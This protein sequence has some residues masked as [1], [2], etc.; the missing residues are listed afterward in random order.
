MTASEII[1]ESLVRLSEATRASIRTIKGIP[2]F[3]M[4][5]K[6][7]IAISIVSVLISI[8]IFLSWVELS[9]ALAIF[10][11]CFFVLKLLDRFIK[12]QHPLIKVTVGLATGTAA[13]LLFAFF[14]EPAILACSY[15]VYDF[16]MTWSKN[17]NSL[18][19]SEPDLT[20]ELV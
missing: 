11:I 3:V 16:I 9:I 18:I 15:V 12:K 2:E 8:G 5:K 7:E 19:V 14:A 17:Y 20:A 6:I 1:A 10:T 4:K 13:A